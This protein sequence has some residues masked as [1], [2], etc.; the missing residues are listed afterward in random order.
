MPTVGTAATLEAA[1]DVLAETKK[2]IAAYPEAVGISFQNISDSKLVT[3]AAATKSA[4]IMLF[5]ESVSLMKPLFKMQ[6]SLQSQFILPIL[7]QA[8]LRPLPILAIWIL[9]QHLQ[10]LLQILPKLLT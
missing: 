3:S 9:Y 10:L 2:I 6:S 1:V 8:L 4:G 5:V 7:P